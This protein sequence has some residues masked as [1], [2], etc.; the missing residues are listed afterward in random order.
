MSELEERTKGVSKL[1]GLDLNVTF[2]P[3]PILVETETMGRFWDGT[4]PWMLFNGDEILLGRSD[5]NAILGYLSALLWMK[6]R[7]KVV[8]E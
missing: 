7:A 2:D 8:F 6:T 1:L 4:V 3:D 5:V